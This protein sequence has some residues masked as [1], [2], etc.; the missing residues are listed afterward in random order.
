MALDRI[1]LI[2]E[3][4]LQTKSACQMFPQCLNTQTLGGMVSGGDKRY[5]AF[6]DEME[7]L[8]GDFPGEIR[9]H[10]LRNRHF[11]ITL[12]PAAAPRHF[13]YASG[14]VTDDLRGALQGMPDLHGKLRQRLCMRRFAEA[15]D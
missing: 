12:R 14:M 5:A 9:I 8:F 15:R 1:I 4:M 11:K 7:I 13:S 6:L 10:A 2:K 3:T